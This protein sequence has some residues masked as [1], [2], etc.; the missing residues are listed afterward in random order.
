MDNLIGARAARDFCSAEFLPVNV[1]SL[2]KKENIELFFRD[3]G[4]LAAYYMKHKE[5]H[6]IVV[7]DKTTLERQ[8]FSIAHE[9]GHFV[10][11]HGAVQFAFTSCR[12]TRP[13][14]QEVQA[15]AFAAE[16][17]MPKLHL[18]RMGH[19]SVRQI[20]QICEVSREAATIRAQDLGWL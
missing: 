4:N 3:L 9:F 10:L 17:L 18:T 7:N 15:N 19:L 14:W 5:T 1:E 8:R 20:M 13:R 6:I 16:T 2:C 12:N 11:K